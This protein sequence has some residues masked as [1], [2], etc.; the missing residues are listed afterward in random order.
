MG[1]VRFDRCIAR[2]LSWVRYDLIVEALPQQ[3]LAGWHKL[4]MATLALEKGLKCEKALTYAWVRAQEAGAGSR[5]RW[6][7]QATIER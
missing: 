3:R 1:E 5:R 4:A 2:V 7:V 6:Q